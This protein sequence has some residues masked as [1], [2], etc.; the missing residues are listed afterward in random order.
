MTLQTTAHLRGNIKTFTFKH[1]SSKLGKVDVIINAINESNG[2][3]KAW[4]KVRTMY[5]EKQP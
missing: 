3:R 1:R 4:D 5:K 2:Y